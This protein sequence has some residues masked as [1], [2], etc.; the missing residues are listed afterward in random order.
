MPMTMDIAGAPFTDALVT[1]AAHRRAA[2]TRRYLMTT[3]TF[4]AVE[5]V[6]N[7]WMDASTPVDTGLALTQWDALRQTYLDLGHSVELI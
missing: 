3:P 5:Y 4:F 6:I 2:S 7:P 1:E